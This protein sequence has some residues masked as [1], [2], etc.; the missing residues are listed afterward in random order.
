[1][2]RKFLKITILASLVGWMLYG[3]EKEDDF[4]P[5]II[6]NAQD[7]LQVP[8]KGGEFII[9]VLSNLDWKAST[10]ADWMTLQESEGEKGKL[11]L[12][13]LVDRNEDDERS[14]RIVVETA[15]G[16]SAEVLV[17]QESGLTFN[18][19]VKPD[20]SGTGQSWEDAASLS[21][22]LKIAITGSTVYLTE[23]TYVPQN[24]VSGGDEG[25]SGDLTFEIANNITVIGGFPADADENSTA[26]PES[27]PTI[28]SGKLD[29]GSQAYHVVTVSA[30]K[31]S[32]EQVL[33]QGLTITEGN[34]GSQSTSA[35]IQGR[36]FRRDYGGGITIGGGRATIENCIIENNESQKF[37]A[38]VYV[39][40]GAEVDIRNSQVNHNASAS[41][42]GG[43]WANQSTVYIYDSQINGNSGGTA[44]GV[45]AYPQ[46]E[47]YIF[48]SEIRGNKGRSY[49]AGFYL[50]DRSKG[51]LVN[52]IVTENESTSANG[53]G[54]VMM[55]DNCE[56]QIVSSTISK[57]DIQGPGGGV[58]RR[59][60]DNILKIHNSIIS[61]NIQKEGTKD[62]DVYEED[63]ISASISASTTGDVVIGEQGNVIEGIGFQ[64]G[65]M[66]SDEYTLIG[67]DNPALEYGLDLNAL[68]NI[69]LIFEDS[70]DRLFMDFF[71]KNRSDDKVMGAI[72][73]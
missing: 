54:G 31:S 68:K 56:I 4:V 24:V 28:L 33:L 64:A 21:E 3:C 30:P 26:D 5:T 34:A 17:V 65:R 69:D 2:I 55:Y 52:C 1:M 22:A 9:D 51:G 41:N 46:A 50:R 62:V 70:E 71:G 19:Y 57:N 49:G 42:G 44:A 59:N 47:I 14:G 58:F 48:D 60:G 43:I 23:G 38:G 25:D 16:A 66:L 27:Y 53:G 73:P 18:L 39:F 13:F 61:G 72:I 12:S 7:S 45:H 11:T 67:D 29:D 40:D 6:L 35:T 63:A 8:N 36:N 20:G 15:E 32:E 37:V 10:N